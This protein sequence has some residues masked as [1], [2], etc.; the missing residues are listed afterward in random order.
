M[1]MKIVQEKENQLLGRKEVMMEVKHE[2]AATPAKSAILKE[3]ASKYGVPE[4]HVVIDY[5]FTSKGVATSEVKA[6]I[7]KEKPKIKVK[8]KEAKAEKEAQETQAAKATTAKVEKKEV[9]EEVKS[10]AQAGK[11]A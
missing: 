8:V 11:P 10:E 4:D 5:V 9:K 3:L 2:A 1:E 6:K 7:Y